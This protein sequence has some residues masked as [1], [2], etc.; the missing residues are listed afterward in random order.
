MTFF[1]DDSSNASRD[2]TASSSSAKRRNVT[3]CSLC[4]SEFDRSETASFPFC[5]SRCK[6]ID[7]GNWL[8]ESYGLPIESGEVDSS[9]LD[10]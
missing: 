9:A 4:G 5:S 7:L 8:G 3:R 2:T 6:Q 1:T 10:E